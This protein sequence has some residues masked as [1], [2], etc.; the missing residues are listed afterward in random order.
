MDNRFIGREKDPATD[1]TNDRFGATLRIIGRRARIVLTILLLVGFS[2]NTFG[3]DSGATVGTIIL[4]T[5]QWWEEG[6]PEHRFSLRSPDDNRTEGAFT[7]EEQRPREGF[8]EFND[9]VGFWSDGHIQF[10]VERPDGDVRYTGE[11]DEE[12]AKRLE[13][14]SSAGELVIVRD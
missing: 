10:T 6:D 11:F 3:C 14:R 2:F 12:N 7:G 8:T 13:F 5:N 4:I 9:L 1:G